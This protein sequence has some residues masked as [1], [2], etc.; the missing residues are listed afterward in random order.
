[1]NENDKIY[2]KIN[3]IILKDKEYPCSELIF[4]NIS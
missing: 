2:E 1:M 3:D 4:L